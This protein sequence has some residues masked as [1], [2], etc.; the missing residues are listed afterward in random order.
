MI[1]KQHLIQC[2]T[3][4]FSFFNHLGQTAAL[5]PDSIDLL[6]LGSFKRTHF[7][8]SRRITIKA[9]RGKQAKT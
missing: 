4:T 9:K 5:K 8:R 1:L 2:K 6:F 3:K 7:R